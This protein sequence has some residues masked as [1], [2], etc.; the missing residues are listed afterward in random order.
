M[1]LTVMIVSIP[2]WSCPFCNSSTGKE[3][4]ASLFGPDMGYNLMV[5][6]LPFIIFSVIIY[7]LYHGGWPVKKPA[8]HLN[9]NP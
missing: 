6:F 2:G 8:K 1:V 4:R 7:L 5:S 9:N 3:I